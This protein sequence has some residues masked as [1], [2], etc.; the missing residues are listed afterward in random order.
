MLKTPSHALSTSRNHT[1]WFLVKRFGECCVSTV[2]T[3]ACCWPSSHCIPALTCV[4]VGRVTSRP[5]TVGVGVRQGCVLSPLLFTVNSSGSQTFRWREPNLDLR[6]CWR[7]LPKFFNTIQFTRFFTAVR[8]LL[9]KISD[10]L[11]KDCW[12]SRKACLGAK[13]RPQ[14]RSWEPLVSWIG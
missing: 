8:S 5:C 12:G 7:V 6:F 4:R 9:H 1:T 11:L 10:V 3:P 13:C 2:L 14:N